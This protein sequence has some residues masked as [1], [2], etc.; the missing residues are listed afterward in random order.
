MATCP[1]PMATSFFEAPPTNIA[2]KNM[3][4]SASLVRRTLETFAQKR[5][6]ADPLPISV[7]LAS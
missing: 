2:P 4:N 3:D 1:D 5:A 6:V 7:R